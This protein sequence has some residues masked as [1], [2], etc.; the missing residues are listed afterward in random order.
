MLLSAF[1]AVV[2][3]GLSFGSLLIAESL[4]AFGVFLFVSFLFGLDFS[5]CLNPFDFH[6][7]RSFECNAAESSCTHFI[8]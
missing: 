6:H 1:E 2:F 8:D 7:L 3:A 4:F 5:L